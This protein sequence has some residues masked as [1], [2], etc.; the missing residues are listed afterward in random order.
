MAF[1]KFSSNMSSASGSWSLRTSRCS[2]KK[3]LYWKQPPCPE[4]AVWLLSSSHSIGRSGPSQN[5][6]TGSAL[7][8]P[9]GS[10]PAPERR[11]GAGLCPH[12]AGRRGGQI[13]SSVSIPC[14]QTEIPWA[15]PHFSRNST[16]TATTG[17]PAPRSSHARPISQQMVLTITCAVSLDFSKLD[18]RMASRNFSGL[19]TEML[20]GLGNPRIR[21]K[22]QFYRAWQELD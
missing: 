1:H 12:P 10:R 20:P 19:K 18:L 2:T 14:S 22:R 9:R 4:D 7:E 6:R 16:C 11:V 15:D 8:S 3:T 13:P 21:L 17:G 5:L